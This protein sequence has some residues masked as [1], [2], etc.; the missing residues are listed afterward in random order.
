MQDAKLDLMQRLNQPG[1]VD[2]IAKAKAHVSKP[3]LQRVA[4]EAAAKA[5]KIFALLEEM[6]GAPGKPAAYEYHSNDIIATLKGLLKTFKSD[7]YE[8]DTEEAS[9]QN[10]YEMEAQARA[11]TIKFTDMDIQEKAKLSADKENEKAKTEQEKEQEVAD[12]EADQAFMKD[13]TEKC[14]I[15]AKDFDQRSKTRAAEIT[16]ITEAI[17]ILKSGVQPNYSANK[18]LVLAS[19]NATIKGHWVWV[20]DAPAPVSEKAA[21]ADK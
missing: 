8:L 10:D 11:N 20:E 2:K 19:Q 16:A 4:A 1:L 15:K 7:K 3:V 21:A 14:E 13:L 18:K 17:E 6:A 9:K 12:M 5:K